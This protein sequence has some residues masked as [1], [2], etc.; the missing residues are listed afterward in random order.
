M[1]GYGMQASELIKRL[2][3]L[4]EQHGDREVFAGGTDYPEGVIGVYCVNT[5]NDPYVRKGS[6]KIG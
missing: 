5:D 6:F 3:E 2:Q 4:I 1:L